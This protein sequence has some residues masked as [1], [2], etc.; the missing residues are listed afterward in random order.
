MSIM[1]L[2]VRSLDQTLTDFAQAWQTGTTTEPRISFETPEQLWKTFTPKRWALLRAMTG[3]GAIPLRQ[4]ARTVG[5]DVKAVHSDVH[6]LIDVGIIDRTEAG[7]LFP[8]DGIHVDFTVMA[9][10]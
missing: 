6:A 2:E 7:F 10:A 1:T 5:R 4:I 3:K 9:V 8:F